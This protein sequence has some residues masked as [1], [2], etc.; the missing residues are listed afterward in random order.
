[1]GRSLKRSPKKE[2]VHA[3]IVSLKEIADGV[4]NLLIFQ[5][6]ILFFLYEPLPRVLSASG[7][8]TRFKKGLSMQQLFRKTLRGLS[9]FD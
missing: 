7:V 6:W 1:L 4:S 8:I 9:Y 5:R 2:Q 3:K